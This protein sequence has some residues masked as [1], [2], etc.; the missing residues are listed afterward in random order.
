MTNPIFVQL[1]Q[2]YQCPVFPAKIERI[3]GCRFKGT[4]YPALKLFDEQGNALPIEEVIK[5]AHGVLE[6]WIRERPEQWLWLHRRWPKD[7][8]SS[9]QPSSSPQRV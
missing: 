1:A 8:E 2:R 6:G 4:V 7:C 5:E 3:E 9:A